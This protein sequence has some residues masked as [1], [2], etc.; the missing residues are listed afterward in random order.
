MRSTRAKTWSNHA[1]HFTWHPYPLHH[2]GLVFLSKG[3]SDVLL[4]DLLLSFSMLCASKFFFE[5]LFPSL[6][7]IIT[8]SVRF[9]YFLFEARTTNCPIF[10]H[11]SRIMKLDGNAIKQDSIR[12][13]QRQNWRRG[14]KTARDKT[15]QPQ[16]A[17]TTKEPGATVKWRNVLRCC[18]SFSPPSLISTM[19][20]T[21]QRRKARR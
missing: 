6:A 7:A 2:N 1:F 21:A 10:L 20:D 12:T 14:V 8:H 11:Q 16:N 3:I 17:A 18:P 15:L 5:H 19:A 13:K 4:I 9:S